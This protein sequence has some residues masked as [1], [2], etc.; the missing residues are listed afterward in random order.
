[1]GGRGQLL[2]LEASNRAQRGGSEGEVRTEKERERQTD[3]QMSKVEG[4]RRHAYC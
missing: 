3:K 1:M 4:D 2:G